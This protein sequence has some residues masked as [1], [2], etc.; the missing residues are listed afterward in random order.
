[1][2]VEVRVWLFVLMCIVDFFGILILGI[3]TAAIIDKI[4]ESWQKRSSWIT[5]KIFKL[6]EEKERI[7]NHIMHLDEVLVKKNK[8]EEQ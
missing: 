4:K 2:I 5:R 1:M 6:E 8:R 3:V 7:D